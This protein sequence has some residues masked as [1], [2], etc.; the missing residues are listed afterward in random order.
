MYD[1]QILSQYGELENSFFEP[2][3]SINDLWIV[4]FDHQNDDIKDM[5]F[6]VCK[7]KYNEDPSIGDVEKCCAISVYSPKYVYNEGLVLNQDQINQMI[8]KFNSKGPLNM[9][10]IWDLYMYEMSKNWEGK[11]ERDII[12]LSIPDYTKL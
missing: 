3:C 5:Y 12:N 9:T 7:L 2:Y 6:K 1:K 8:E 4:A 10:T 11:I